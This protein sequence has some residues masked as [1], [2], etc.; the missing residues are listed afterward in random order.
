MKGK[1]QSNSEYKESCPGIL[2]IHMVQPSL[3]HQESQK[4]AV[5]D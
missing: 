2:S 4:E 3:E 1:E 5:M